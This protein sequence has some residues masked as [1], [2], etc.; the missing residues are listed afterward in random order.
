MS[1]T[2]GPRKISTVSAVDAVTDDL[3]TAIFAGEVT[4]DRPI[5]ELGLAASYDV[6][7]PTAKAAIE[8]LVAEGLLVRG[9][10]RSARVAKMDANEIRD[11]YYARLVL[12]S[13]VMHRLSER[14]FVPRDAHTFN[15]E[16]RAVGSVSSL[17]AV[18]PDMRFHGTL[19]T[20]M[21]SPRIAALYDGLLGGV[22]LCM[23]RV[24]V[25]GLLEP[26]QIADEHDRILDRIL[27]GDAAGAAHE[28]TQHFNQASEN[29]IH[30]IEN[31]SVVSHG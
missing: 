25:Y 19:V 26:N 16:V 23:S 4:V 1:V 27:A 28:L 18:E 30:A 29:L 9:P 11:L 8:R 5:T 6:A 20:A 17:D 14:K 21:G 24:Q 2:V 12:E 7:R 10:N 3:R 15:D 31:P 13:E 22:R